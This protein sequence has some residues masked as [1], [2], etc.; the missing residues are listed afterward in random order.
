M[1]KSSCDFNDEERRVVR[2]WRLASVGLYGSIAAGLI[3]YAAFG[4][5]PDVNYASAQSAMP[6]SHGNLRHR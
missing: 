6:A 3:L 5:S 2:R 4:Q 1:Q